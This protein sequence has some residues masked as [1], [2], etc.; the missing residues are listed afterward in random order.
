MGS[1]VQLSSSAARAQI[2]NYSMRPP[3]WLSVGFIRTYAV[4]I[5]ACIHASQYPITGAVLT[6]MIIRVT[7]TGRDLGA[8]NL[9]RACLHDIDICPRG[10]TLYLCIVA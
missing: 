8:Y 5:H 10:T 4:L 1:D 3:D 6:C 7:Y 9:I 2:C